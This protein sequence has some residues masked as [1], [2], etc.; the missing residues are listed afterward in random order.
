MIHYDVHHGNYLLDEQQQ[1]TLLDFEMTCR[2]WFIS[3]IATTFYYML[4]REP[5]AERAT[6]DKAIAIPF[7]E[8]YTSEYHLADEERSMIPLWML[9]RDLMVLAFVHKIWPQGQ[10]N[11]Q[12]QAYQHMLW[13]SIRQRRAYLQL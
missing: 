1:I 3:D 12:Q 13:Q 7:W 5:V 6:V 9:Y 10:L 4:Q 11:E 8:G 2:G